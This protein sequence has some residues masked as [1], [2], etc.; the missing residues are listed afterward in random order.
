MEQIRWFDLLRQGRAEEVMLAAG[1]SFVSPKHLLQPIPQVEIDLS[2]G[3]LTQNTG[4]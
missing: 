4:W 3:S 1:K 2:G